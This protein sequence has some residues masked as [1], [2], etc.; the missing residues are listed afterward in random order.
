MKAR[1]ALSILLLMLAVCSAPAFADGMQFQVCESTYALC[2]TASCNAEKGKDDVVS[3]KC[4]VKTGYSLGS[5]A[6]D[7]VQEPVKGASIKSRYY[8]I[9]SVVSCLNDEPWAYC[10]DAQCT[11][12]ENGT[13]AH[14]DCSLA[15]STTAYVATTDTYDS[16]TCTSGPISS[17]TF[18]QVLEATE[19]LKSSTELPPFDIEILNV[20]SR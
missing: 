8:P 20:Q 15:P 13:T 16:T 19:F 4:D 14:C 11:I 9:K 7:S 18:D 5:K 3:C 1:K 17:A 2:T 10:L 12:D 6:C